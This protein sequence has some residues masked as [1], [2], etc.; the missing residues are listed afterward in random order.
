MVK[1]DIKRNLNSIK[2]HLRTSSLEVREQLLTYH[3]R[4]LLIYFGAPMTSAG[5]WKERDINLIE[6]QLFRGIFHTPGDLRSDVIK[7]LVQTTESVWPTI[8][9]ISR[10]TQQTVQYQE[11]ITEVPYEPKQREPRPQLF[12]PK[13]MADVIWANTRGRTAL[14]YG[15]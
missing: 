1:K 11:K 5:F 4:S 10:R 13:A 7:N 2:R 3:A 6:K 12:I 9:K 14:Y 8:L 15:T